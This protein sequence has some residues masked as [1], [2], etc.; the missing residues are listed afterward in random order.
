M[1]DDLLSPRARVFATH[2]RE[3]L[4]PGDIPLRSA[5]DVGVLRHIIESFAIVEVEG[6]D[7]VRY[8]LVG[9]REVHRYGRD[10]TGENYLDFC[11]PERRAA[12]YAA[13]HNM[14][15][16]PCGMQAVI[17]S[18]TNVAFDLTN[19]SVGFPFRCDRTG[20]IHLIFQSND[21]DRDTQWANTDVSIRS[22]ASVSRRVYLDVGFGV[23]PQA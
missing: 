16:Y 7:M 1:T 22:H 13:F 14:S 9:A 20:K 21:L 12:A 4:P 2:Y 23:P 5:F 6:P 3:L 8:R 15:I 17:Q 10:I 18:S 19:E 11:P